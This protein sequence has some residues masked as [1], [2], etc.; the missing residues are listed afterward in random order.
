MG[1]IFKREL[2]DQLTSFKFSAGL[3]L[4]L[5]LFGLNGVVF[6]LRYKNEV[7][8]YRQVI[9]SWE[10]DFS[11]K[12]TLGDV[13]NQQ[14]DALK[15]PLKTAFLA[16]GGQFRLPNDYV[17]TINIWGDRPYVR[18]AFSQN[19]LVDSFQ[20]LDWA[21]LVGTAFS[22][23][24][25]VFA[26]DSI[27][28][29]KTRGTLK[30][31]QTYNLSR[32][33]ILLGKLAA[34]LATLLVALCFG[35]LLSL[36]IL[37]LVGQVEPSA[38]DWARIG[39]FVVLASLYLALFLSLSVLISTLTHRP[40]ATMVMAV[41]IWVISI[42]V[43]PGIGSLIIQR[44]RKI[45]TEN[46]L[47]E[48]TSRVYGQIET[49][50]NYHASTWRGRD[51][52]KGDDYKFEKISTEAQNKRKHMQEEM[53]DDYLR[54]KLGQARAVRAISSLSPSGLF[55]F[56]AES[57][58]GTG[59]LREDDLIQL[60]HQYRVTVEQWIRQRDQAATD[61]AHLYFQPEY[62]SKQAFNVAAFPRFEY[63]EP[64]V[65]EGLRDALWR[66]C[67]LG[68]EALLMLFAAVVAFQRY[69]VR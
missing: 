57:V 12:K 40:T 7:V 46:E 23:L 35:M 14:F 47:W 43:I 41:M 27:S 9:Q 67:V 8:E 66:G 61:S 38:A 3:L 62:L 32:N 6:S 44:V 4:V 29:E 5:L 30:L 1:H 33:S 21:F 50:Y 59:V 49:E 17:F 60:A 15:A 36:L 11:E 26:Y 25:M 45:P 39:L 55:Q 53:W 28:G 48:R 31:L 56:G 42:V 10:Q 64:S 69:D 34:N 2:I 51:L 19:A 16:S 68:A 13:P 63:R 54:Q 22:L 52:A 20:A 37:L 65:L 24:A 18:R 58:N